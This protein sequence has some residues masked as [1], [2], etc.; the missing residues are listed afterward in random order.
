[1]YLFNVE[2]L[3]A[4]TGTVSDTLQITLYPCFVSFIIPVDNSKMFSAKF[5][6]VAVV[7]AVF[8]L[9]IMAQEEFDADG[10]AINGTATNKTNDNGTN[11]N[12]T[13]APLT[14]K[15]PNGAFQVSLNLGSLSLVMLAS[16]FV[17]YSH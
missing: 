9:V 8:A 11:H 7:L 16:L 14:T 6:Q 4:F 1:M 17:F 13:I 15:K 12:S 5:F 3:S 2:Y 10:G